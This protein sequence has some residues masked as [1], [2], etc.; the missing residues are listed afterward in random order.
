MLGS[1]D[2]F[3]YISDVASGAVVHFLVKPSQ[4]L[5]RVLCLYAQC[6][7]KFEFT[8]RMGIGSF[9]GVIAALVVITFAEP[10]RR[11]AM[12]PTV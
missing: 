12:E 5:G 6:L 3:E 4:T 2:L 9:G 7:A 11:R 10:S 8:Q 1:L